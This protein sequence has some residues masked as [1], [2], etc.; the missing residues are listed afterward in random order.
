MTTTTGTQGTAEFGGRIWRRN[1]HTYPFK[2]NYVDYDGYFGA[3]KAVLYLHIPFCHTKCGFCDYT[4]Y[5]NRPES[6][7]E[8]YV[9]AME[10]E[11]RAFGRNRAFPEFSVDAV[12]FGGGTP[13]ILAGEQIARIL[14]ACRDS[15]KFEADAEIA[16]EFDPSTVTAEKVDIL[17]DVGFN[18][19]SIGIQ[20]FED[21]LLQLCNRAHDV[22]TAERAYEL[23]RRRFSHVNV[24]LIF[25]LPTLTVEEWQR[26]VDK[27]IS[28]EPGCVTAYGLEIWPKTAFHYDLQQGRLEMPTNDD[29]RAMYE[30]A[31]EKLEGAGFKRL[32]ST[33]YFH[34]DRAPDYC[35]FLNYY[36]RT[37]PMIGFGVSAKSVIHDRLYT[38]VKPLKKYYEMI[39]EG[40]IPI[41]FGTRISKQQEMRRVMIRGLKMCEISRSSFLDR[42]GVEMEAVFGTELRELVEQ[43]LL[44][45]QDD[46]YVLT[47]EGQVLSTNVYERFYAEE[48]LAPP[49]PGEVQFG[50]SELYQ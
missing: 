31:I 3:E 39:E 40:R 29:E 11:I 20:S 21:R 30:Y 41:D 50:I 35:R 27:A 17:H 13:G 23:V 6:A 36:W 25:P 49:K 10:K 26:S 37:W 46:L 5:I 7:F 9:Q 2:Y 32:S 38:N 28:L 1:I 8:Q 22:A 19:L 44:A 34:P 45:Q 24:D 18:R 43:G 14:Q 12:Y 33:G 15:F 47:R 4:V 16:L 48:D 42:F